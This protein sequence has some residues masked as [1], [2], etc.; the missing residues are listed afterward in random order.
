MPASQ[1]RSVSYRIGEAASGGMGAISQPANQ[2]EAG[3]GSFAAGSADYVPKPAVSRCSNAPL[4]DHLV[5]AGEQRRWHGEVEC[6]GGLE[7]D[8]QFV[9]CRRLH[10][11]VSR[12]L[13]PQD[14]INVACPTA[15]LVVQVRPVGDEATGCGVVAAGVDRG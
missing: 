1:T 4:F 3:P 15:E 11:H 12:L 5:G 7:V 13:T 8:D 9:L 10:W 14:A 6:F 2:S